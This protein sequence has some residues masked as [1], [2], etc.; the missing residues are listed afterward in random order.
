MRHK[1]RRKPDGKPKSTGSPVS[2]G[3]HKQFLKTVA[4]DWDLGKEGHVVDADIGLSA[5][6]AGRNRKSLAG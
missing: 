2:R 4:K 1:R 5:A 3:I 6:G